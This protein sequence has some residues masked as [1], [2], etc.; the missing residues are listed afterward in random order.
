VVT[1]TKTFYVGDI[2]PIHDCSLP[3]EGGLN[4]YA[5]VFEHQ[6]SESE[7]VDNAVKLI[8]KLGQ[9]LAK[10]DIHHAYRSVHYK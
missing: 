9:F 7:S 3:A 10:I 1:E 6:S 8:K 5:P 2:R 4:Y